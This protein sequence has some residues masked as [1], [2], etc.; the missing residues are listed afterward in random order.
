VKIPNS[1]DSFLLPLSA[2]LSALLWL[3]AMVVAFTSGRTAAIGAFFVALAQTAIAT[4]AYGRL[5][6]RTEE[7]HD[8]LRRLDGKSL[9]DAIAIARRDSLSLPSG[10]VAHKVRTSFLRWQAFERGAFQFVIAADS[11]GRAHTFSI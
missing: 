1:G 11:E 2:I 4:A 7:H 10:L 5:K 9:E 6:A 3:V 8:F